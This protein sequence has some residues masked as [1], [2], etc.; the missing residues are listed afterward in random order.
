MPDSVKSIYRSVNDAFQDQ[1]L[2]LG[3]YIDAAPYYAEIE[4]DLKQWSSVNPNPSPVDIQEKI[5]KLTQPIK[6]ETNEAII[7]KNASR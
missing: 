3:E 4:Q 5:E 1:N 7:L 6:D 2:M